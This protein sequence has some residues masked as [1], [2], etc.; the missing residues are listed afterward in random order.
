M[1]PRLGY[2]YVTLIVAACNDPAPQST[3]KPANSAISPALNAELLYRLSESELVVYLQQ[4]SQTEPDLLRR[5]VLLARRNIGQPYKLGLLGEG[6]LEPYDRDS[7]YCLSASDCVT[8]VEHTYA[9][10][11]AHDWTSF[12]DTLQRI[13]YKDGKIGFATRNHF[14][15]V[16]WNP[17]NAWLFDDITNSLPGIAPMHVRVDRAAFFRERGLTLDV[18]HEDYRG[19]YVPKAALT[20][21]LP[22]IRDADVVEIVRGDDESQ[23]ISHMGLIVHSDR[24]AVMLLHSGDPA[25]REEPLSEYVM[26]SKKVLGMKV[27]RAKAIPSKA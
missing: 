2:L 8:F 17:N 10:A 16:D 19:Y 22:L 26:R 14:T 27:L 20:P 15:E 11:L 24:G 3:S 1:S 9:M 23:Y 5:V 6:G 21:V 13:R 4:L 18:P 25:V 12:Q 7:L